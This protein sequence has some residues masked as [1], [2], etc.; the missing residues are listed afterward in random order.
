MISN[1]DSSI[2]IKHSF[3][4]L[5]NEVDEPV[6]YILSFIVNPIRHIESF[7]AVCSTKD[8][9]YHVIS[10]KVKNELTEDEEEYKRSINI[11]ILATLFLFSCYA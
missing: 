11:L 10:S 3:R 9:Q 1:S 6:V 2:F 7:G 8:Y 5:N 4:Q